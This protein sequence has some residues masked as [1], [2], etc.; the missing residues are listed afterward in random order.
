MIPDDAA[1]YNPDENV[2]R[3]TLYNTIAADQQHRSLKPRLYLH[4]DMN[5]F[6]A[7]VEQMAYN[8]FGLPLIIGGWR[9]PNGTAR[10]I[11]ATASYEARKFGV[12]TG[13]SAFEAD[14]LCPFLLMLKVDYRKYQGISR[15]LRRILDDYA[16]EVEKY[17]MD[18][19]FLD[20]SFLLDAERGELRSFGHRLKNEIYQHTGLVCSIGISYS[21]TY[22]KLSSD[23]VKPNGLSLVLDREEASEQLWPLQLDEVWGI[24]S[25]RYAKILKEGI[26][27]IGD[28]VERG[29]PVFQRLFGD[30]FGKMLWET[31]AGRD[32]AMVL[33][34]PHHVPKQVSYGHT[35]SDWTRDPEKVRG[36]I[37][38]ALSQI[39]YRLRAYDR[40]AK[41]FGGYIQFQDSD[42][43]GAPFTFCTDGYTHIDH[44]VYEACF[45]KAM[46]L[47]RHLARRGFKMRTIRFWTKETDASNQLSLFFEEDEQLCKLHRAIDRINNYYGR[48]TVE[49][50]SLY[51]YVEGHTHFKERV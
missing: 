3:I 47:V 33:D 12:K 36:E 28:G 15:Q 30:Y 44:Y 23:L 25:R 37:A 32:R 17:S 18:E 49:R 6:Y 5:C 42:Y 48:G 39:C 38:K 4:L 45:E 24:G 2:H 26:E 43:E 40:R 20:I 31:L 50:A 29:Y 9:K 19:Y 35:F 21:K 13:M 8:L 34:R 14:R 41:G 22:A 27:T 46:P 1:T 16:P 51:D 10:G 7:Q 11:V